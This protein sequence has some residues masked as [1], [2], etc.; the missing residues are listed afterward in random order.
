MGHSYWPH[1]KESTTLPWVLPVVFTVQCKSA[2]TNCELSTDFRGCV[3]ISSEWLWLWPTVCDKP[4]PA[5]VL[6]PYLDIAIQQ[7]LP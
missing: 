2:G 6:P 3:K 5:Y 4:Q 7:G 1:T